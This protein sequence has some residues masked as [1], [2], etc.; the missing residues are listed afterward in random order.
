V[1]KAEPLPLVDDFEDVSNVE[2]AHGP[3]AAHVDKSDISLK[4]VCNVVDDL[5]A[6]V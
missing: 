1:K 4:Q 3:F 2:V 5:I 6:V